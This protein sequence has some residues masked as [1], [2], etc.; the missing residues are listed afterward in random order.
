MNDLLLSIMMQIDGLS[1]DIFAY[2]RG[3]LFNEDF[4]DI[5]FFYIRFCLLS[6][7]YRDGL[8]AF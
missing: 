8:S 3:I 4:M 7:A 2:Q 1:V 6:D 5:S